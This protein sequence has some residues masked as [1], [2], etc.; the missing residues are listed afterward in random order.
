MFGWAHY[1]LRGNL[2]DFLFYSACCP[3]LTNVFNFRGTWCRD[4]QTSFPL[5]RMREPGSG[6]GRRKE[7]G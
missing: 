6:W 2:P 4:L 1:Q 3:E 5:G 7:R